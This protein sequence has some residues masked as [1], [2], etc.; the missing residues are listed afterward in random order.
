MTN[1]FEKLV[2]VAVCDYAEERLSGTLYN[3]D[4]FIFSNEFEKKMKKMLK[5]EHNFYHKVTLTR[6]RKAICL[7]A[8]IIAALFASL[9][10]EAGRSTIAN[11]LLQGSNGYDTI[12][13]NNEGETTYPL[14]I[15]KRFVLTA[16]PKE[17][18]LADE[19]VSDD[20][21]LLTY[22]D[23]INEFTFDQYTKADYEA[24]ID[25][26]NSEN[27]E[28]VYNGQK[29]L[30]SVMESEEYISTDIIWDN[31]EYVFMACGA[32][33]KDKMLRICDSLSNE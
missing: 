30:V 14:K 33:P 23:G 19:S 18:E 9:S 20:S 21:V 31:G 6:A 3:E 25:N 17:Y 8:I 12:I 28:V 27:T 10:V 16:L 26:E 22:S 4:E 1:S 15:E 24:D 32:F 29:Y 2:S 5:S 7:A 13:V 11:F